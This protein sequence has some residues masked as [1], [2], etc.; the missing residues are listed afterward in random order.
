M[1][2]WLPDKNTGLLQ[3]TESKYNVV[4]F[5]GANGSGKSS[6]M[7]AMEKEDFD[8]DQS[9]KK[10]FHYLRIP[11]QRNLNFRR[12][13]PLIGQEAA[14]NKIIFGDSSNVYNKNYKWINH[15][16]GGMAWTTAITDDFDAVLANLVSKVNKENQEVLDRAA[17][18][19][20][21]KASDEVS[22]SIKDWQKN[23]SR[24]K[25]KRIWASVLPERE[26][27][28]I[29]NSIVASMPGKQE[30]KYNGA[31]MSDGERSCLYLISQCLC[32]PEDETIIVDEPELHLHP[33]IMN[34][35]WQAIEEA[36]P[37]CHYIFVTH[38]LEF[39][40]RHPA[41]E[42]IWVK[43]YDGA[44][45]DYEVITDQEQFPDELMLDILGSR[46]KILL[47]EG[48]NYSYDLQLYSSLFNHMYVIPCGSCEQVIEKVKA[49]SGNKGLHHSE[50]Y[51]LIDRD[52]RSDEQ[53]AKYEQEGI[54]T[55]NVAE[56]ENLFLVRNLLELYCKEIH[57]PEDEAKQFLDGIQREVKK[58][59]DKQLNDQIKDAV[60]RNAKYC[61]SMIDIKPRNLEYQEMAIE[62]AFCN[63][64]RDI[65]R[66][67][68]ENIEGILS[69]A[70]KDG[71][72]DSI[73]KVINDKG[74][75]NTV[76][77][78]AIDKSMAN[79]NSNTFKDYINYILRMASVEDSSRR[80]VQEA[81]RDYFPEKLW[82]I[83]D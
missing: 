34:R 51:G 58:E 23:N 63:K 11:A 83:N 74:L 32:A 43:S 17:K 31:T 39:A 44:K 33:S 81:L 60:V 47:V 72:Y 77:S 18:Q 73:L 59:F 15:L 8:K 69:H 57:I 82:E 46:R 25:L 16:D 40:S 7:A 13:F 67:Q 24:A 80:L 6:L 54:F 52:Y 20:D 10:G 62:T 2:Y 64:M 28:I 50:V 36:R 5:I 61:A 26:I 66:G 38:D 35:L 49:F 21:K 48:K 68:W 12:N 3:T 56:V 55:L 70:S 42:L 19:N 71:E 76:I 29:D 45:W 75:I 9:T 65:I 4:I 14:L 37:D 1:Q 78:R 27:D 30:Q 79:I 53:I 22:Q 41:A